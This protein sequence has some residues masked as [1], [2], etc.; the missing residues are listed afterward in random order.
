MSRPRLETCISCGLD[1]ERVECGGIY[2]CPNPVCTVTG[3]VWARRP[4]KSYRDN[5]RENTHSVD[6]DELLAVYLPDLLALA[7]DAPMR[8]AA[9]R[10][11]ER[12][13][14]RGAHP[15]DRT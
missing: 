12:W 6:V 4:L 7:P 3:A 9:E 13:K 5:D 11:V 15:G 14:L 2:H 10:S 1:D 8:L